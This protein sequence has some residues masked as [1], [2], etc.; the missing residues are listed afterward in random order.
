MALNAPRWQ[1]TANWQEDVGSPKFETSIFSVKMTRSFTG[2]IDSC[3]KY[4]PAPGW[5]APGAAG[6]IVDA[7]VTITPLEGGAGR[8][9]YTATTPAQG[10]TDDQSP[11]LLEIDWTQL[12]KRL[13][14][15][16]IYSSDTS[17]SSSGSNPNAGKYA[18]TSADRGAI[19]AWQ[20]IADT[21][22]TYYA[23][24]QYPSTPGTTPNQTLSSNAQNLAKK[25]MR[26]EESYVLYYPV[27]RA[28]TYSKKRPVSG[29]CGAPAS[30][31]NSIKL[32]G[33]IYLKTAD[34]LSYNGKVWTRVQE[35]TGV[36][37]ID[38]DLYPPP[39]S[40]NI[41]AGFSGTD[42]WAPSS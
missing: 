38:P 6:F 31:P 27:S 12:Q 25:L 14:D 9:T 35:W 10:T 29:G 1:G 16:P 5:G 2:P 13:E 40:F 30:P 33:Y 7:P 37:A 26:G 28:T 11:P 22:P 3:Y 18:L 4:A 41:N 19:K 24:F 36:D 15:H 34:R 20:G 39:T 32:A 8:L 42:P 21:Y 17:S 23:Q